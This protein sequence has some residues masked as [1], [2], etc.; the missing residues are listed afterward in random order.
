MQRFSCDCG[1][2]LFFESTHCNYCGQAVGYNPDTKSMT[3]LS[4]ANRTGSFVTLSIPRNI[5]R[6]GRFEQAKKRLLYGLSMLN[7]PIT[8]GWQDKNNGVLFDFIEDQRS[9]F[10]V[11]EVQINTGHLDGVIT[12]NALEADDIARE[13]AKDKMNESYRTLLGHLRHEIGHYYYKYC[14]AN[15]PGFKSDFTDLFGD[16]TLNYQE[17]LDNYYIE[18]SDKSW[19]DNYV[20]RYASSHPLEDWAECWSHYLILTDTLESANAYGVLADSPHESGFS[21][22]AN[23]WRTFSVVLNE[24]NRSVGLADAYPFVMNQKVEAKLTLVAR[25]VSYLATGFPKAAN[26]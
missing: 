4:G 8:N 13:V 20:S 21:S 17:A 3:T 14:L 15:V 26:H 16:P 7:L 12:V 9:N 18:G 2:P 24:L 1:Q 11:S 6:W 10:N 25:T 22:L 5:T 23:Q 19:S